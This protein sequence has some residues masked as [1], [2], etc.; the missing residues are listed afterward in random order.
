[1]LKKLE[2]LDEH[3]KLIRRV[4]DLE[5]SSIIRCHNKTEEE[6]DRRA[7]ELN[8][9]SVTLKEFHHELSNAF[10]E[11][12]VLYEEPDRLLDM[13]PHY[14]ALFVGIAEIYEKSLVTEFPDTYPDFIERLI[15]INRINI[16]RGDPSFLN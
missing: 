5:H 11:F 3:L 1:M 7:D 2:L 6:L 10:F 16:T 15:T 13:D 14:F 9:E 4:C 8:L 12:Q